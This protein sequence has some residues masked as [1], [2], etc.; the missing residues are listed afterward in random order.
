VRGIA[1]F[2]TV[3]KVGEDVVAEAELLCTIKE[4]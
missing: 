1:K 4:E 3:A 2:E